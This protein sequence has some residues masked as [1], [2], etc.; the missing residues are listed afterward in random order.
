MA[1]GDGGLGNLADELADM[2]EDEEGG[3]D[4]GDGEVAE[5]G[6]GGHSNGEVRINGHHA[7]VHGGARDGNVAAS[8]PPMLRSP[9]QASRHRSNPQRKPSRFD[10][11][12]YGGEQEL[13]AS[14]GITSGLE[15]EIAALESIARRGTEQSTSETDQG[16]QRF[17]ESLRDLGSQAAIEA[18]AT[19][20]V[21]YLL[22]LP[23]TLNHHQPQTP[24]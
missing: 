14:G 16:V 5:L 17:T 2:W 22:T 20:C 15:A 24:S 23:P 4:H 7:A 18:G 21:S 8:S 19:R 10:G 6:D 9:L 1:G 13:D 3:H 11:S 12:Q